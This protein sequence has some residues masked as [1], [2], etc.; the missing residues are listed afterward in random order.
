M[1]RTAQVYAAL[2][3]IQAYNTDCH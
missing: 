1:L 2:Q 3:S